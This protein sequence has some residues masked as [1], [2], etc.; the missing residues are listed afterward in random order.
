LFSNVFR[1]SLVEILV[2]IDSFLAVFNK[3]PTG[4]LLIVEI[5]RY[6]SFFSHDT[7]GQAH[8]VH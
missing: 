4:N 5:G 6:D 3:N 2:V 7:P 8:G 1:Q